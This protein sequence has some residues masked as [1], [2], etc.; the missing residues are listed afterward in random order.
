MT[1]SHQSGTV[2][3]NLTEFRL[4]V[5]A[6]HAAMIICPGG[7]YRLYGPKEMEPVARWLNGLGISAFLLRYPVGEDLKYTPLRHAARA[8]RFV[9]YHAVEWSIRPDKIGILGFS[10]GGHVASTLGT[11]FDSGRAD[12]DDPVERVGSRPDALVL[13]YSVITMGEHAHKVC[14]RNLLGIEPSEELVK[15]FSNELHVTPETPPT[16]LWHSAGDKS[17]PVMNSFLFAEALSR[18][19][20]PFEFHV[21]P[22]DLHGGALGEGIPYMDRWPRLCG[23][24][25]KN[26]GFCS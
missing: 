16:F 8:M 20:V 9:R 26:Q 14:R 15:E 19:K 11:H 12:A 17:V 23:E 18:A 1:G 5:N 25:L 10:A 22:A 24:W 2:E 6:P 13:A 7:A 21:F 3:P 4:S